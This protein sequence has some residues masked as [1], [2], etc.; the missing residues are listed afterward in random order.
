MDDYAG[1]CGFCKYYIKYA[2]V[3][4]EV[5]NAGKKA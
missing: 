2:S 5:K 3:H 1:S 4:S